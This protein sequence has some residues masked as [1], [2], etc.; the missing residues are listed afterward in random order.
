MPSSPIDVQLTT[1]SE[2]PKAFM[3]STRNEEGICLPA[4][5]KKFWERIVPC[6]TWL[7]HLNIRKYSKHLRHLDFREG[8]VV[9]SMND[10]QIFHLCCNNQS[11]IWFMSYFRLVAQSDNRRFKLYLRRCKILYDDWKGGYKER[12][13]ASATFGIDGTA[14]VRYRMSVSSIQRKYT[15]QIC[16][17]LIPW[18]SN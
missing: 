14:T 8:T 2:W 18:V 1:F 3:W 11:I 17:Y 16:I 7:N 6:Q 15:L 9:K 5:S 13:P 4:F 12:S 10:H